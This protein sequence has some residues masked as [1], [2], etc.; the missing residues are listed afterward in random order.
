MKSCDAM[1]FVRKVTQWM[2]T[3][4]GRFRGVWEHFGRCL[5]YTCNIGLYEND[6]Y[7]LTHCVMMMMNQMTVL[8]FDR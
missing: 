1:C 6:V 5:K 8:I 4:L 3:C 2:F 7:S